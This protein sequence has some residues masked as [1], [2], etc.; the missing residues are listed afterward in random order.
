LVSTLTCERDLNLVQLF[1]FGH[2]RLG[3]SRLELIDR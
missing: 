1:G 3:V 2:R